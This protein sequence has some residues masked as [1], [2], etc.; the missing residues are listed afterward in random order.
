MSR[1]LTGEPAHKGNNERNNERN[2][3]DRKVR[4][5]L[6]SS[7]ALVEAPTTDLDWVVS[8]VRRRRAWRMAVALA[9][10]VVVLAAGVALPL[11]VFAPAGDQRPPATPPA[12]PATTQPATTR[13]AALPAPRHGWV[14]HREESDRVAIQTPVAWHVS[15]DSSF[16]LVQPVGLFTVVTGPLPSGS[17]GN[18]ASGGCPAFPVEAL[19]RDGALFGLIEYT[20]TVCGGAS[21]NLYEFPPFSDH[22]ELGPAVTPECIGRPSHHV[23]F[24]Q[25]G[26][27]FQVDVL[28][29]QV[30]PRSLRAAVTASLESVR[31]DP[32]ARSQTERCQRQWVFCPEAAWVF[33]VLD[34][35]GLFHWGNTGTAI[36]AVPQDPKLDPSRKL[37]QWTT[38]GGQ[39]PPVGFH[40]AAVV[41]GIAVYGDGTRL[42][43]GV[44]GVNVWVQAEQRPSALPRGA[45]LTKLVRA[46]RAVRI[47]PDRR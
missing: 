43:W 36:Q 31:A 16:G 42:T 7:L 47:V 38:R 27:Y 39:L 19:S 30:A 3:D 32:S 15:A 1:D 23:L 33:Q 45:M 17:G 28:F 41:D 40:Q 21:F 13:P 5:R 34:R 4:E 26:R 37:D 2:N 22:L 10:A 24:Q 25:A 20:G 29:G 12:A 35:A 44:Q 18:G 11:T 14:W 8:R 46:S 6:R 9:V